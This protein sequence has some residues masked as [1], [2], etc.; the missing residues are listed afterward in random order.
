MG[1]WAVRPQSQGVKLLPRPAAGR[2]EERSDSQ[3]PVGGMRASTTAASPA[4]RA[5]R[6]A[7]PRRRLSLSLP[8]MWGMHQVAVQTA[9]HPASCKCSKLGV[10]SCISVD[11]CSLL[12]DSPYAK[13]SLGATGK[14]HTG[15][16]SIRL[17]D[18]WLIPSCLHMGKSMVNMI[19]KLSTVRGPS[20]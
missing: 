18:L 19:S 13:L 1:V 14:P 2:G 4:C 12:L 7:R 10:S 16:L 11:D 5:A 15:C 8:A 9:C 17:A 6:Q 20:E 3:G